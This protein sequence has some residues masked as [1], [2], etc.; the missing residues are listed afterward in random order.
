MPTISSNATQHSHALM[1]QLVLKLQKK[2]KNLIYNPTQQPITTNANCNYTTTTNANCKFVI[3]NLSTISSNAI[4]TP[5]LKML[6]G[7]WCYEFKTPISM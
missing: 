2:K 3:K 4:D 6:A 1:R 7:G 5:P